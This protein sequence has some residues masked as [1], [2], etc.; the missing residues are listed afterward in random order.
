MLDTI[1]QYILSL[2]PTIT[3]IISMIT[4]VGVSIGNIRK[5]NKDATGEIKETHKETKQLRKEILEVIKANNELKKE[6]I[7]LKREQL[8]LNA[9]LNHMY[10]V[11]KEEK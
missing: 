3:A 1:T 4:L 9:R 8:K 10:F 2:V 7:E 11:E 6:N 5:A